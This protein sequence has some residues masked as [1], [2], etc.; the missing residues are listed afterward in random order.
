MSDQA[1]SEALQPERR[2]RFDWVLPALFRPRATFAAIAAQAGGVW[3]APLLLL[4]LFALGRV[5]AAGVVQLSSP[6]T[7][8]FGQAP[9]APP[10]VSAVPPGQEEQFQ[11]AQAFAQNP[12]FVFVIPAVLAVAGVWLGWLIVGGVLHLVFT[13]LGGRGSN[14]SSLNVVAWA[15]LPFVVRDL[16]RIIYMLAAGRL[17]QSPGLSGLVDT[18]AGG[19]S[20]F[21]AGLL[22]L[23]DLYL[24]WHVALIGLGL[25]SA[26]RVSPAKAWAG[27][28][29]TLAVL[30]MLQALPAFAA[31]QVGRLAGG[32]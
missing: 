17:I 31:A 7:V 19:L 12:L 2:L 4:T 6:A 21:C 3:L 13:L 16:V 11:Q 15:A 5:V 22:G 9:A 32:P 14:R 18:Q 26:E 23:F 25:R 8:Q 27:A 29:A 24:I 20:L 1:I 10:E 28:A 30:L